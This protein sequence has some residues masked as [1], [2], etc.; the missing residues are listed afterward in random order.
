MNNSTHT[1]A[2]SRVRLYL[3]PKLSQLCP[4][5]FRVISSAICL[6]V[7]Q[8][9]TD[10]TDWDSNYSEKTQMSL[11]KTEI[12]TSWRTYRGGGRGD[13]SVILVYLSFYKL[14]PIK[15][16]ICCACRWC[17]IAYNISLL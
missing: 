14:F 1:V 10:V 16:C 2:L 6:Q 17:G 3:T 5:Q 11:K 4:L 13:L 9:E 12:T 7:N 15:N 8:L